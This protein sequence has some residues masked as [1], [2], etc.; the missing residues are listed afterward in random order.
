MMYIVSNA[1]NASPFEKSYA[2]IEKVK[3]DYPSAYRIEE[4]EGGYAIFETASDY[5]T[6]ENQK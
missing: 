4:V 1:E 5:T 6:W 2:T 3:K